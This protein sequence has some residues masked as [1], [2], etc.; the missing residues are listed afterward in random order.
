MD[1]AKAGAR[2]PRGMPS[3]LPE[4]LTDGPFRVM[5]GEYHGV[6]PKRLRGRDMDRSVWGVRGRAN[7]E[8]IRTRCELLAVRMPTDA[9]FSHTTA[10]L[11]L[12]IPFPPSLAEQRA[13]H[14]SVPRPQRAPHAS[15]LKGH[16]LT[17]DGDTE[18]V[19]GSTLV[20]TSAARTWCDL[21]GILKLTDLV[22]AGDF[23]LHWENPLTTREELGSVA[24]RMS[25]RRGSRNRAAAFPLLNDRA[26]SRPESILRVLIHLAGLPTPRIY[27][28][29]WY[30]MELN[31][32]DLRNPE[33]LIARI[34]RVLLKR[35]WRP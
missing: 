22:A 18:L 14:V 29:G 24:G 28:E 27:H 5:D 34:R 33:E 3:Q 23:L 35:G 15:G 12:G 13:I 1:A 11:L 6:T 8:S 17:I 30:V 19:Y 20:H 9:F 10:A 4:P 2:H 32:D 31:A 7:E 25:R 21:S 16:S 26:E